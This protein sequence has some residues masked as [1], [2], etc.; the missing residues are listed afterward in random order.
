ME[1]FGA[2][3]KCPWGQTCGLGQ[4]QTLTGLWW[5]GLVE[6]DLGRGVA[7]A[8]SEGSQRPGL[9]DLSWAWGHR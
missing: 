6:C 2:V 4:G 3:S 1:E 5:A 9:W 8:A 7:A